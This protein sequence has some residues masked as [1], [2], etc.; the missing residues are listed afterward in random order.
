[1][2]TFPQHMK[3][4][5]KDSYNQKG[6]EENGF[7]K[8]PFYNTEEV[9]YLTKLYEDLHPKDETGFFPSTFSKDKEYRKKT[10]EEIRRVGQRSIS[11]NLQDVLVV[12]GSYIVKYPDPDSIMGVH[13]DMT[14][15][16]ES[17]FTGI[18]IWCPLIDLNDENGVL[19]VLP[20]SHRIFPTYRGASIPNIYDET[21]EELIPKMIPLFL[22]AGEAVLFDQSI[23]HYSPPNTSNQKRIVTNTYF[24][25]KD[26]KFRTAYYPKDEHQDKVE[27]FEQDLSF[28]TNFDQFGENI[29]QRP[30][31]GNSIGLVDYD[32]PKIDLEKLNAGNTSSESFWEKLKSIFS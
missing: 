26:V 19:Y 20:K 11:E 1:M 5:F 6:F 30:N 3:R 9:E 10:D 17:E 2:F 7:I 14:L 13:Q 32:F 21:F 12:C 23:I 29:F 4:V 24:S 28:M 25:H 16:D 27:L 31:I 8:I 22:K 18:N 15:V